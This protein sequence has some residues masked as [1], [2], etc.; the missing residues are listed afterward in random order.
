MR[1]SLF[2]LGICGGIVG[3]GTRVEAQNYPWCALYSKGD[4][5]DLSCG[6]LSFEQCMASARTTSL[7]AKTSINA[8]PMIPTRKRTTALPVVR[9][10]RVVKLI[11]VVF[12]ILGASAAQAQN[13]PWCLQPGGEGGSP[14]CVYASF[15]QCLADRKGNGFCIQNSTQPYSPPIQRH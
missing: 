1:L 5:A 9:R 3:V 11:L 7:G 13:G 12:G 6:F 4:G 15:Q 14:R 10:T 8:A 2:M